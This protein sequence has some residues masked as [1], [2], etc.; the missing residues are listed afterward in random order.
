[1][2]LTLLPGRVLGDGQVSAIVHMVSSSV[3]ELSPEDV[4]VVDQNGRLLSADS[5][6]NNDLDGS[7][8][9]YLAEVESSYQRRIEHILAP[10]LGE[11][12]VRAQVAAQ[13]DFSQREETSERYGPNQPPNE[14][15]VRSR[16]LS[17]SL[18]GEDPLGTGIP[19]ALSNTPRGSRRRP[20]ISPTKRA[21]MQT[22]K[23]LLTRHSAIFSKTMSSTT[24]LIEALNIS[25]TASVA[26]SA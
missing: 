2:V 22:A 18:D 12:N 23:R 8:L 17:L 9:E 13:V 24:R 6:G 14:A 7:Q 25:S 11:E 5:G 20:S 15:A 26:S 21:R 16:Q 19:G 10:I 3:P 4:S 1:M